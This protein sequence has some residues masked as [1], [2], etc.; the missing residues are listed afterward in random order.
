MGRNGIV[1]KKEYD[2]VDPFGV[3]KAYLGQTH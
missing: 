2:S 3:A 1:F